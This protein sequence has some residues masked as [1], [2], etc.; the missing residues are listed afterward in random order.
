[1]LAKD[2]RAALEGDPAAKGYD[3][4]I[5]QLSRYPGYHDLSDRALSSII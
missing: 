2:I 5:F 1:M 3:E 4:I